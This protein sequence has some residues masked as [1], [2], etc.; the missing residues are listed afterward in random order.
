MNIP[1]FPL[2]S[3]PDT[4]IQFHA[5][6]VKDALK[7]TDLNPAEDEVTTTEYLNAMQDG[8]VNDSANWTV[9]DRRTALWWIFINSRPDPVMTYSYECRH[10]G[11]AHHADI[12][13]NDLAET[14][15]LLTVPPYI[16]TQVPVKGAMT[17]WTLKP[18]SGKGAELLER[19]RASLPEMKTPEYSAAIARMRIAEL[20][21]CTA[22]DDDPEDFTEAANRRFDIIETMAL[23]TE[24][25]PLVARIQL[26]QRDLRHGLLMAIERGTSRLILPPQKCKNAKEGADVS[27]TLYVPFLNREFIA[28]I[29][30]EWMANHH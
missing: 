4:E 23:E 6:T 27:T 26:M 25:T 18:L 19:M 12:D 17:S 22:L 7:Y 13:L 2:P 14:A 20:A 9:Q 24:F 3:S 11:E 21:L 1:K 28:S 29:R 5:P 16:K 30:P 8:E 15:E 10:C